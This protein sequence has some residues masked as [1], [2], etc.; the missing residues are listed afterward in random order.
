M[1]SL[2]SSRVIV[3]EQLDLGVEGRRLAFSRVVLDEI[4]GDRRRQPGGFVETPVEFDRTRRSRGDE[5]PI[6]S[7]GR[8]ING[9]VGC[10]E[11]CRAAE[12]GG[13]QA[14][15]ECRPEL[16]SDLKGVCPILHL[17]LDILR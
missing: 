2:G 1:I 12:C 10:S 7:C 16:T 17:P 5:F 8:V 3:V 15:A 11:G 9:I 13:Q 4:L 6:A 14:G